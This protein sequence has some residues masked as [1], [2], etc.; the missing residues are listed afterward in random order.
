MG[1]ACDISGGLA[2]ALGFDDD[3]EFAAGLCVVQLKRSLRGAAFAPG[4]LFPLRADRRDRRER[5]SR[6][7]TR[8][9][10]GCKT[11]STTSFAAAGED[12]TAVSGTLRVGR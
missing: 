5:L 8:R 7:F 4:A 2:Q 12:K 9:S 1:G 3:D 11:T 10:K 6:N